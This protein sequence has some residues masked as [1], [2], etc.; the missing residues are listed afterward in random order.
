MGQPLVQRVSDENHSWGSDRLACL[1]PNGLVQGLI[2]YAFN[3][4]DMVGG[5]QYE[6][7]IQSDFQVDGELF[8]RYAQCSALFPMIQFSTAPWKVLGE[9]HLALY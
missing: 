9:P 4:P 7:L 8:V 3:C 1:I 6:N 2:G 5:G